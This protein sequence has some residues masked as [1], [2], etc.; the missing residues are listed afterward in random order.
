MQRTG[1]FFVW[2]LCA[3]GCYDEPGKLR[4]NTSVGSAAP[5]VAT[6]RLVLDTG[7]ALIAAR[8]L[9]VVRKRLAPVGVPPK[10]VSVRGGQIVV[11]AVADKAQKVEEALSGGRLD[12]SSGEER[13]AR[14]ES[15]T[16][17]RAEGGALVLAFAGTAKRAIAR[18][19][20]LEAGLTVELDGEALPARLR[21]DGAL[22]VEMDEDRAKRMAQ[23][24]SGR[25][26]SH[27]TKLGRKVK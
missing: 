16:E 11:D 5:T 27:V 20:K 4:G 12:V 26:L 10:A 3:F 17:A 6:Q 23:T 19:A 18:G 9:R 22:A 8:V 15:L 13:L 1:A 21:D 14:G 7:D 25:A 24:L 2:A